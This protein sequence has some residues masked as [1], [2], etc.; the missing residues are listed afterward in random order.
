MKEKEISF[1]N[2]LKRLEKI[3][4]DLEGEDISLDLSLKKYEEGIKLI[5]ICHNKL[6]ESK[7]KVDLLIK[8]RSCTFDLKNLD[9]TE[10]E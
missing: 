3:A 9:E 2:A 1:E 5:S 4:E 7:R 8:K 6:Q 10:L